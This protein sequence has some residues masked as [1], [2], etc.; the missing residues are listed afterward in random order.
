MY[1]KVHIH[2]TKE[3]EVLQYALKDSYM[4]LFRVFAALMY[5]KIMEYGTPYR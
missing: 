5:V 3:H 4:I 2:S 1:E